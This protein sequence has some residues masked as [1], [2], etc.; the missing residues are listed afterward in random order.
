MNID[1]YYYQ[2]STNEHV[3]QENPNIVG[4]QDN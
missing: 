3:D 2:G 1:Y 4:I